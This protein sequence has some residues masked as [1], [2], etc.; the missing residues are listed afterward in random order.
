VLPAQSEFDQLDL[1]H[2]AKWMAAQADH[3]AENRQLVEHR[4]H[5]LNVSH[6]ARCQAVQDQ[7]N[8][9]TND[10]IVLMKQSELTRANADFSERMAQLR[11]FAEGG[12]IHAQPILFGTLKITTPE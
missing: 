3:I 2:H 8:R 9:A 4:I 7:I 6:K 12:D 1:H 5:S 11:Q 10:K